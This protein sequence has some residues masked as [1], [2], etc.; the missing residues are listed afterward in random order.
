[1]HHAQVNAVEVYDF[2]LLVIHFR[3]AAQELRARWAEV[4][5]TA[6]GRVISGAGG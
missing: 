6:R 5:P 3:C 2:V 4:R 1:M